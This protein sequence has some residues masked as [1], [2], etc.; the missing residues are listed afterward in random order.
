MSIK[1]P[2]TTPVG[3]GFRSLNV[4]LR[5]DF[6]LYACVRPARHYAGVPSPLKC[7]DKVDIV[8]FRENTE[9]VYTGLEY[10]TGTLENARLAKFL[11][12]KMAPSFSKAPASAS[13]R[14]ANSAPSAWFAK[15]SSTPSTTVANRSPWCTRATS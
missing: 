8:L 3:G 10:K 13:S 11:R 15:P 6:D 7:P 4:A 5:Q 14:S 12:E 2:L 1:G 9:D